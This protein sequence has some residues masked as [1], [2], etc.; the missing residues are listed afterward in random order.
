MKVWYEAEKNICHYFE[1]LSKNTIKSTKYS[2]FDKFSVLSINA[3]MMFNA[4]D[5]LH[6]KEKCC[7][8]I[9]K[10]FENDW[11][12]D[13]QFYFI[14]NIEVRDPSSKIERYKK[15]WKSIQSEC[16]VDSF[17]KGPEIELNVEDKLYF[18][19]IASFNLD[20][21]PIA[22]KLV[23]KAP[24]QNTI[25]ASRR[26]HLLNENYISFLLRDSIIDKGTLNYHYLIDKI[27]SEGD[28]LFR[29]G[30]LFEEAEIALI[31]KNNLFD[32]FKKVTLSFQL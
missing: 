9:K 32:T 22:L 3:S 2:D 1:W 18:S 19:S 20:D 15:L 26:D 14:G 17:I 16:D 31:F 24:H 6:F 10:I 28:I 27:C 5:R 12:K 29:W 4:E 8:E 30:D 21:F 7:R 13:F 11:L 25:F 23:S